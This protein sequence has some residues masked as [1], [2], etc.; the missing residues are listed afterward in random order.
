MKRQPSTENQVGQFSRHAL[1]LFFDS[2]QKNSAD[3]LGPAS[4]H[5]D[6]MMIRSKLLSLTERS[7]RASVLA[8]NGILDLAAKAGPD[9]AGEHS[10]EGVARREKAIKALYKLSET[11]VSAKA[12]GPA[13]EI[14]KI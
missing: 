3:M 2:E 7:Y 11:E 14:S 12:G 13:L 5:L 6:S 10:D 1:E 4:R 8:I 9:Q